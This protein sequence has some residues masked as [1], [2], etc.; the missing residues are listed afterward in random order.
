MKTV[1]LCFLLALGLLSGCISQIPYTPST[2]LLD[3]M[4]PEAAE[5]DFLKVLK[6]ST[7][8]EVREVEVTID[9]FTYR[10]RGAA[11]FADVYSKDGERGIYF[12][13][14]TGIEIYEN[15]RV[16]VK[17]GDMLLADFLFGSLGD[18]QRFADLVMSFKSRQM[19]GG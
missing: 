12:R 5:E 4:G 1:Q 9:S 8:P 16:F 7:R 19:A 18:C 2:A 15:F 3:E 14:V 6:R 10:W 11:G 17:G 13:N